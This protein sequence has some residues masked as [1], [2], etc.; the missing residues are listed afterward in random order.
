MLKFCMILICLAGAI[1]AQPVCGDCTGE[2]NIDVLDVLEAARI[3]I[4]YP[5]ASLPPI[6]NAAA[7]DVVNSG[8]DIIDILDALVI[9]QFCVGITPVLTC[10]I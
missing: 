3:A 6:F 9:A 7:C 2:G 8:S 1:D 10:V 4:G 5:S